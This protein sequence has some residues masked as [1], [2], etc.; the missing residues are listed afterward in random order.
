M[1]GDHYDGMGAPD[2]DRYLVDAGKKPLPV[3]DPTIWG[4][5]VQ[6]FLE[7]PAADIF[8]PQFIQAGTA[9]AF[10][11]NW[12][13]IGTLRMPTVVWNTASVYGGFSAVIPI[14]SVIMGVGQIQIEHQIVLACGDQVV[15]LCATQN[16]ANGG[17]YQAIVDGADTIKPF[18]AVGALVG[19]VISVRILFKAG[20]SP[21]GFP[22]RPIVQAMVTPFAAGH[23]L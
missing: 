22:M 2:W 18:A 19:H 21:A 23:G 14:L 16:A 5:Q 8:S 6:T 9:D 4:A 1:S 13:I 15:G 11:R 12:A 17:P 3:G 10:S 20:G 7:D